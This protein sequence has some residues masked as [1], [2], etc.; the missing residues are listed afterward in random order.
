MI[1]PKCTKFQSVKHYMATDRRLLGIFAKQPIAGLVKTRL[2]AARSPE[3][4]AGIAEAF[5]LDSLDRFVRVEADRTIVYAPPS[6]APYFESIAMQRY[7][8]LPQADGDLGQRLAAFF[9]TARSD[10]YARIVVIGSDSPTMP[11][12]FVD[13]A[14]ER[15]NDH[16]VVIG[17]AFDGGYY[18]I[19]CRARDFPIFTGI[20]WSTPDV[21]AA[22]RQR[23]AE[24]SA[25]IAY[26]PEWYDV[27]T[28]DDWLN[29]CRHVRAT[30]AAGID[31]GLSHT[32]AWIDSEPEA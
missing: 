20:P 22:T 31:P 27:D 19:G 10:A 25:K 23:L 3:W 32:K 24:T 26:C 5:L 6:A 8:L 11:T 12:K 30:C 18:L 7:A 14:F 17:P 16:D 21:L 13:L 4:A 2:A 28:F 1:V 29:L 15:L 9:Q